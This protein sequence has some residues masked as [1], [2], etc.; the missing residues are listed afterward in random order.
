MRRPNR[1]GCIPSE[2][3]E[4]KML[5]AENAELKQALKEQRD[6]GYKN[7]FH[8]GREGAVQDFNKGFNSAIDEAVKGGE[9]YKKLCNCQTQRC[10][11][12]LIDDFIYQI[13]KLK[14]GEK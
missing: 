10:L 3:D 4:I 9:E 11:C 14:K 13:R 6:K 8:D 12:G 7:G 2:S 5:A 1:G